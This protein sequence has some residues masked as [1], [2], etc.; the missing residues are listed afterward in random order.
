MGKRSVADVAV[1]SITKRHRGL[2]TDACK[3]RDPHKVLDVLNDWEAQKLVVPVP[4]YAQALSALAAASTTGSEVMDLFK[5]AKGIF[6]KVH[7]GAKDWKGQAEALCTLMIRLAASSGDLDAA[8]EFL[9]MIREPALGKRPKLRTFMPLLSHCAATGQWQAA[10]RI[11]REELL[12]ACRPPNSAEEAAA[13]EDEGTQGRLWESIFAARLGALRVALA[14]A[15]GDAEPTAAAWRVLEELREACP[16]LHESTGLPEAL[17][18]LFAELGWR[19]VPTKVAEDGTCTVSGH[20]LGQPNFD[21]AALRALLDLVENLATDQASE[22]ALAEW[23][24]FK[25]ALAQLGATWDTI[26]DG[27]NVGHS[28]QNIA[29]G[30]F[31]RAR[32]DAVLDKCTD[33]GRRVVVVVRERWVRCDTD[34]SLPPVKPRHRPLPQ[35]SERLVA[36]PA[37]VP[38]ESPRDGRVP[39]GFATFSKPVV[40][41]AHKWRERG[42]LVVSPRSI[43]DDWVALYIA[44]DMSLRGVPDVQFLTNDKLRDHFWRMRRSLVFRRWCEAHLTRFQIFAER[45]SDS[46][47]EGEEQVYGVSL[48]PPLPFGVCVQRA[49]SGDAWHFPIRPSEHEDSEGEVD[50]SDECHRWV[51]AL[52]RRS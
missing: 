23:R 4:C 12:A 11:Y 15:S 41:L 47:R 42:Q 21:E 26:V 10:E 22:K 49:A 28:D 5:Y 39:E 43:N 48:R 19:L 51:V 32:I 36:A 31:S 1:Q 30:R 16:R 20:V 25:A 14:N 2:L 18:G 8:A 44:V 34:L 40:D 45:P 50:A 33:A 35:L 9:Q 7:A 24:D 38:S 6:R 46:D 3:E 37:Q 13:T 27:A 17:A 29:N 52:P